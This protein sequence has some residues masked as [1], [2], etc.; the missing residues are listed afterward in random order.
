MAAIKAAGNITLT[1]GG[2]SFTSAVSDL[3]LQAAVAELETTNLASTAQ[4]YIPGLASWDGSFTIVNHTTALDTVLYG[5]LSTMATAVLA[6]TDAA[7]ATVTYT[8]TS[9]AFVTGYNVGGSP[10]GTLGSSPTIRFA[11][12][13][14]SRNVA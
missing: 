13:P 8:W 9:L 6:F 7:A 3:Q 5:M 14:S 10:S 2:T 12:P 1:L 4:E 11:G